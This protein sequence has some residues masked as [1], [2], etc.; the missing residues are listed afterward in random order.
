MVCLVFGRRLALVGMHRSLL[1]DPTSPFNT[2][3]LQRHASS[4][5]TGHF[6]I[7]DIVDM[8]VKR[9]RKKQQHDN[10]VHFTAIVQV[11]LCQPAL[12]VKNWRIS[13][14]Q[15]FTARMLLLTAN[16][17]VR[18]RV[19]IVT[20]TCRPDGSK[21]ICARPFRHFQWP[22]GHSDQWVRLPAWGFLFSYSNHSLKTHRF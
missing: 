8:H 7:V 13:L 16:K 11:I 5:T 17:H 10:N 15:S 20:T 9:R 6:T 3:H 4:N 1:P 21:T 14:V 2:S 19:K 18:K 12:P 22:Y